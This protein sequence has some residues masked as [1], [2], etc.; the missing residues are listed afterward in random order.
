MLGAVSGLRTCSRGV[1]SDCIAAASSEWL[2]R[3]MLFDVAGTNLIIWLLS[4]V[5]ARLVICP[6]PC[7]LPAVHVITSGTGYV[8]PLLAPGSAWVCTVTA[9]MT[10]QLA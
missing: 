3:C 4:P 8:A 5:A 2:P 10:S 1:F 9:A 7:Q 6:V